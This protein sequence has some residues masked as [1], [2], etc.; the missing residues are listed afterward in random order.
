MLRA[1]FAEMGVYLVAMTP[2]AG[3]WFGL[4]APASPVR[5]TAFLF[6]SLASFSIALVVTAG[7]ATSL[8]AK[9]E[10]GRHR[11]DPSAGTAEP[12]FARWLLAF[13][14]SSLPYRSPVWS[15]VNVFPL[16]AGPYFRLAGAKLG[17]GTVIPSR[18]VV[19]DPYFVTLGDR[20]VL[21]DGAVLSPHVFPR[22]NTLRLGPIELAEDA[23]VGGFA[24]VY[25][26]V[27]IG[28]RA[29]VHAHSVVVPGTVIGADEVWAGNPAVRIKGGPDGKD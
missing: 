5:F 6:L 11:H 2:V 16:P 28:P 1:W 19:L 14:L 29:R 21:G 4:D 22:R 24:I 18:A 7:F 17:T 26:D 9:P 13:N 10:R 8:V 23:M 3:L 27:T 25:G 12:D 15:F 20:V